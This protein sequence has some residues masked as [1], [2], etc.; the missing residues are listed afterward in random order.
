[1]K[2]LL[3][4]PP[5]QSPPPPLCTPQ[6]LAATATVE[7]TRKSIR[8]LGR[9]PP[10]VIVLP[11]D[12][13]IKIT[14]AK[15][16]G[17]SAP[18]L[19]GGA[20]AAARCPGATFSVAALAVPSS[21]AGCGVQALESYWLFTPPEDLGAV[22]E[23]QLPFTVQATCAGGSEPLG[24]AAVGVVTLSLSP[25]G[26]DGPWCPQEWPQLSGVGVAVSV[27]FAP[28]RAANCGAAPFAGGA[29]KAGQVFA[30]LVTKVVKAGS[31][32]ASG[33]LPQAVAT[34]LSI[35]KVRGPGS[36]LLKSHVWRRA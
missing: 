17:L 9:T 13:K 28:S 23:F 31:K 36:F 27:A 2:A 5:L 21:C 22:K 4:I 30:A 6:I 19:A 8:I 3:G 1:M 25:P 34:P 10:A 33:E 35:C 12:A 32:A 24:D 14:S 11:E 26:W 15:I 18:K 7:L 20:E 16:L 29:G